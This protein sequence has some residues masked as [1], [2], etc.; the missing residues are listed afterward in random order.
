[1][2]QL[3][4][5]YELWMKIGCFLVD[6]SQLSRW[7][8]THDPLR[9][10]HSD[11]YA[12]SDKS[13]I[14][15]EHHHHELHHDIWKMCGNTFLG[16]SRLCSIVGNKF[17]ESYSIVQEHRHEQ[18]HHKYALVFWSDL[19]MTK[20]T[21]QI[22]KTKKIGRAGT[23]TEHKKNYKNCKK[24]TIYKYKTKYRIYLSSAL[25]GAMR[26][27]LPIMRC[28]ISDNLSLCSAF[29]FLAK[30]FYRCIVINL[31]FSISLNICD[32]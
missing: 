2:V 17:P 9:H 26:R 32:I 5:K 1:M 8:L 6:F 25:G 15:Q 13:P 27:G 10:R 22:A 11:H 14:V 23:V 20:K 29:A 18:I 16:C 30:W 4:L 7:M 24:G 3:K 21:T 19:K 12:T 31:Y 28:R